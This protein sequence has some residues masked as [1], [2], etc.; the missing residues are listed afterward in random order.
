MVGMARPYRGIHATQRLAERKRRFIEAGLELLGGQSDPDELTV[1]AIC[2]QAGLTARYFYESFTDKDAFVEA[3]FDSVTAELAVTTQA[4]VAAAPPAEQNRAGVGNIVQTIADDPR[5][6]RLM[7]SPEL[8]N[9]AIL[10][11]R[12]RHAEW[13]VTLGREHI[14]TALRVNDSNRLKATTHFVIGGLRQAINGWLSGEV[15]MHAEELV[16]LLVAIIDD[17]NNPRLFRD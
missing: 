14:R 11:A 16:D 13:F 8:S 7:F 17:L 10:R 9:A 12:S 5:V 15:Q 2:A 1:R 6:G 4:A 3:V